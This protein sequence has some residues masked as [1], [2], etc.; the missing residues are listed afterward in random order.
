[1]GGRDRGHI[2]VLYDAVVEPLNRFSVGRWRHEL[3]GGLAGD[4]LEVGVGT[5]L[6]LRFYGPAARVIGI[7]PEAALLAAALPRAQPRGYHLGLADAQALPFANAAFDCVVSTLVFCTIPEPVPALSEIRRVLRPGGKLIQ[8]EH[9]R[10]GKPVPDAMLSLLTPAWS[11][12]S[13]GCHLNR[14]TPGLLEREGWQLCRH[15]RRIGGL[16][17]LLEATPNTTT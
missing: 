15:E 4:I 2:A 10:T 7:D 1:M 3:V 14:D 12:I 16:F 8:L 13:G 5:G 11:R 6:N 9:T 17:R